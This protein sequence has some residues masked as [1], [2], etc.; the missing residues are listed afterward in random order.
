MKYTITG[1]MTVSCW[2]EVEA[3]SPEEAL[4]IAQERA[5]NEQVAS[6][7]IF[8]GSNPVDES[9]HFSNDGTPLNLEIEE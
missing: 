8:S 6:V 5:N 1:K 4:K 3:E 9:F 7:P 2:T